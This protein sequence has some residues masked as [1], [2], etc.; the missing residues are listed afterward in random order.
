MLLNNLAKFTQPVGGSVEPYIHMP[1]YYMY[2]HVHDTHTH[3]H[4]ETD[5][6]YLPI[7]LSFTGN[8]RESFSTSVA[9][10]PHCA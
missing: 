8:L 9:F 2:I 7:C 4:T 5:M 3:I 1:Q 10:K 6:Y